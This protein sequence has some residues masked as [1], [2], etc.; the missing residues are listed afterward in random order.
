MNLKEHGIIARL[1]EIQTESVKATPE[2]WEL[3]EEL[4]PEFS[5]LVLDILDMPPDT[6]NHRTDEGLSRDYF[7]SAWFDV[8]FQRRTLD[9]FLQD[10]AE[11]KVKWEADNE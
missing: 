1:A 10:C 6:Y 3:P 2:G 7:H 4:T 5:D 8:V 9:F 11:F